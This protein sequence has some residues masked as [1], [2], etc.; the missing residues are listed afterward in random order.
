MSSQAA[1]E[2]NAATREGSIYADRGRLLNTKNAFNIKL[3]AVPCHQFLAERDAAFSAATPTGLIALDLSEQLGIPFRAHHSAAIH[4]LCTRSRRR[5]FCNCLQSK[6][7][8]LLCD[9]G[10][11]REYQR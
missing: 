5:V 7:R 1:A 11:G 10:G 4:V 2:R 9:D 3:P 6:W 8:D